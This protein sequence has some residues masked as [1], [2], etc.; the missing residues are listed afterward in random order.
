MQ[1]QMYEQYFFFYY[2]K[3]L[4]LK[5][6]FKENTLKVYIPVG[7]DM[8]IYIF[9]YGILSYIHRLQKNFYENL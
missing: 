8:Y 7:I 9:K 2:I 5:E 3:M 4:S 6:I 1:Y